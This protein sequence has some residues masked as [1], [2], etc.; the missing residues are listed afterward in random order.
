M[1]VAVVAGEIVG[2]DE[3]LEETTLGGGMVV[4]AT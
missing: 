3:E 2:C 4:A 1:V